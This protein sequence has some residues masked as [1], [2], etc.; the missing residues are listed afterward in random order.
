MEQLA[1]VDEDHSE[2]SAGSHLT[3]KSHAH[4]DP[5]VFLGNKARAETRE[6][7]EDLTDAEDWSPATDV[8]SEQDDEVGQDLH[9]RHQSSTLEQILLSRVETQSIEAHCNN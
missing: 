5:E 3:H 2:G 8:N 7:S 4:P 6:T 9:P 1:G